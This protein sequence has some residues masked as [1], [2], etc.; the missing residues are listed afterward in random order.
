MNG[1]PN[2]TD[3]EMQARAKELLS[4]PPASSVPVF[5]KEF[6]ITKHEQHYTVEGVVCEGSIYAVNFLDTL[7]DG[8]AERTAGEWQDYNRTHLTDYVVAPSNL[9]FSII[10][11]L[12]EN[13]QGPF[14]DIIDQIRAK[15]LSPGLG[16]HT[17]ATSTH[18]IYSTSGMDTLAHD[19][20][21][22]R[23]T[24]TSVALK[25]NNDFITSIDD[26]ISQMLLSCNS[27]DVNDVLE[28][29]ALNHTK[30]SREKYCS[31]ERVVSFVGMSGRCEVSACAS[32]ASKGFAFGIKVLDKRPV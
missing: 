3:A 23:Q 29:V 22:L 10:K 25:G 21:L 5:S 18:I 20:G 4:M 13:K 9:Q 31:I 26:A 1:F 28:W 14:K 24:L 27:R 17:I 2:V 32:L 7:L 16:S 8:R 6:R 12:Y 30:L 19:C 11:T 15:F